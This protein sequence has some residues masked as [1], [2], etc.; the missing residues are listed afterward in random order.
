MIIMSDHTLLQPRLQLGTYQLLAV[1]ALN[2]CDHTYM[3]GDVTA[4]C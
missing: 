3:N 4:S 1:Q 2:T